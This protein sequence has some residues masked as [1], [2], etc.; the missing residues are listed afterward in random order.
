MKRDTRPLRYDSDPHG[1]TRRDIVPA[2]VRF[3]E[4][5]SP[6]SSTGPVRELQPYPALRP[7]AD[8]ATVKYALI[9][10]ASAP[11][12]AEGER[13][14]DVPPELRSGTRV[15]PTSTLPPTTALRA[16]STTPPASHV[17]TKAPLPSNARIVT[18]L[19]SNARI[20]TPPPHTR[21]VTPLPSNA[22]IVTPLPRSEDR[23]AT[24]SVS[25]APPAKP[26]SVAPPASAPHVPARQPA[27]LRG[28]SPLGT[29][30]IA[31]ITIVVAAR[32]GASLGDGSLQRLWTRSFAETPKPAL[33]PVPN[34]VRTTPVSA[35]LAPP[36]RPQ[37]T[38]AVPRSAPVPAAS[39]AP[40][41]R[42]ED[43]PAEPTSEAETPATPV[44]SPRVHPRTHRR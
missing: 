42:F 12:Y 38:S 13:P 20:V 44:A 8:E 16:P 21:I 24:A 2:P 36:L 4:E 43:L 15:T 31:L 6:A 26:I 23:Y 27:P 7:H 40:A 10:D 5:S 18:P 19:P 30:V 41:V 35:A 1:V 14:S 37:I 3:A 34:P 29:A 28:P 11:P 33:A 25:F 9:Q 17:K 39:S 22:R 32:L